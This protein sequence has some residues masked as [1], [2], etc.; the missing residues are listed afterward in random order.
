MWREIVKLRKGNLRRFRCPL[1]RCGT[2]YSSI[3]RDCWIRRGQW[4]DV[5]SPPNWWT[6]SIKCENRG[7]CVVS[8]PMVSRARMQNFEAIQAASSNIHGGFADR[9]NA[10]HSLRTDMEHANISSCEFRTTSYR[11]RSCIPKHSRCAPHDSPYEPIP[12]SYEGRGRPRHRDLN[13]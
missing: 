4:M 12:Y 6:N 8:M 5:A 13:T 1:V 9:S 2:I 11:S 3:R 7:F 10:K